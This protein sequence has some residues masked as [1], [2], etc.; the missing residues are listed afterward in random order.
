V[1]FICK[2]PKGRCSSSL[3]C[4]AIALLKVARLLLN[5]LDALVSPTPAGPA[6]VVLD[7]YRIFSLPPSR[8]IQPA[9]SSAWLSLVTSKR[10]TSTST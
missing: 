7:A 1:E 4:T 6:A 2:L 8:I 10:W 3:T 5:A 9:T